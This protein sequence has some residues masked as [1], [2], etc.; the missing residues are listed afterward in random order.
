MRLRRA[1]DSAGR[2]TWLDQ[3]PR[4]APLL[5]RP[6]HRADARVGHAGNSDRAQNARA[7]RDGARARWPSGRAGRRAETTTRSERSSVLRPAARRRRDALALGHAGAP[8]RHPDHEL[9]DAQRHAAARARASRSSRRPRTGSTRPRRTVF[10]LV[11]DELHMY[12]GTPGTE[13]AYLLRNL[14]HRLGLDRP[15][16]PGPLP[17]RQRVARAGPR[18]RVPRGVLRADRELVRRRRTETRPSSAGAARRASLEHLS[19]RASQLRGETASPPASVCETARCAS[20]SADDGAAHALHR[21]KRHAVRA[22]PVRAPRRRALPRS[23]RPT[24]R[25]SAARAPRVL[26]ATDGEPHAPRAPTSSSATSRACGPAATRRARR[27][28]DGY[29]EP[30]PDG[31]EAL[32]PAAATGATAARA[33]FELLYCQTCGDLFLGGFTARTLDRRATSTRSSFR[34][35]RPRRA[36]PTRR[37]RRGTA[38]NYLVYWPRHRR[39]PTDETWNRGRA[40]T[41]RRSG[42]AVLR[43]AAR[44]RL[45]QQ[46]GQRNRLDVP[47]RA[48]ARRRLAELIPPFPTIC[49]ACGDD[50]EMWF[51]PREGGRSRTAA[52]TRS[53]IRGMRT[54]FEKVSQVLGDAL[55]RELR[56]RRRKLVLFSDSRQDAAKL[57]AG[58]EKRHYQDLVRQLLV[59]ALDARAPTRAPKTSQASRPTEQR[60][61]DA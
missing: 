8:A 1:L 19:A 53:P 43:P 37:A 15:A 39:L 26:L 33:C 18:R 52:R 34:T 45:K 14:L 51:R 40:Y 21:T 47:R 46:G 42:A 20:A 44:R 55:L 61:H 41:L 38:T 54:G 5:L 31:R 13:V 35:S 3:Q 36:C 57:S 12:R 56:R 23:R 48:E 24:Q 4:R 29:E 16:G 9:L 32:R 58:F 10:T 11:V 50:W 49:P 25:R 7:A 6:L 17:R 59:E 22:R 28:T 27:S 30:R 60:R 2:A